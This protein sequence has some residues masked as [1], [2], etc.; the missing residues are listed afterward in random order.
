[1]KVEN[2]HSL[3][4]MSCQI[5]FLSVHSSDFGKWSDFEKFSCNHRYMVHG[6][7]YGTYYK[8]HGTRYTVQGTWYKV[9]G[10]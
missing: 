9:H 3:E 10:H 2:R 8:V 1:M 5:V 7:R 6:T 4:R